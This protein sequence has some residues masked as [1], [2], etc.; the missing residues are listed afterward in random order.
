MLRQGTMAAFAGHMRVFARR[1]GLS[2]V[3]VAHHAGVLASVG[4]GPLADQFEGPG[5]VM[6]V[7][8][9]VFRNHRGTNDKKEAQAGQE[10]QRGSNEVA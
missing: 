6:T 9:E 5:A 3:V 2:H 4:D 1:P 7:L 10:H 8:A